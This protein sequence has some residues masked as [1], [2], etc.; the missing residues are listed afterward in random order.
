MSKYNLFNEM[1]KADG[2]PNYA[3][4]IECQLFAAA[5]VTAPRPILQ[6]TPD[7]LAA[8]VKQMARPAARRNK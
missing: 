3:K 4:N 2:S 1:P 6:P 8:V 5:S 7:P